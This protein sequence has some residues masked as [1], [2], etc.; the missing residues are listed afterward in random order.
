MANGVTVLFPPS[1]LWLDLSKHQTG[2]EKSQQWG[3]IPL[4]CVTSVLEDL[5]G[6]DVWLGWNRSSGQRRRKRGKENN[7]NKQTTFPSP[8]VTRPPGDEWRWQQWPRQFCVRAPACSW[9]LAWATVRSLRMISLTAEKRSETSVEDLTTSL[10][11]RIV[12]NHQS[13]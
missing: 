10:T 11:S 6:V 3:N 13:E 4:L 5:L 2:K 12:T 9:P 1:N 8:L 7:K